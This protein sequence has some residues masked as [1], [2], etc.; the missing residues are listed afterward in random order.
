FPRPGPC[1][2]SNGRRTDGR[3][4]HGH[5]AERS[6]NGAERGHLPRRLT[7][8]LSKAKQAAWLWVPRRRDR[9]AGR[10]PADPEYHGILVRGPAQPGHYPINRGEG[11][12]RG[13]PQ[14]RSASEPDRD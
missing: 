1:G 14:E 11:R 8:S 2:W 6:G 4:D 3:I 9:G 13:A 5:Y 10:E 7:L 12:L